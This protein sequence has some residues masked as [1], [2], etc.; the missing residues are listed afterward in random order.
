VGDE[1]KA[2]N[3]QGPYGEFTKTTKN[4]LYLQYRDTT[5]MEGDLQW[6]E[7]KKDRG[8]D[9]RGYICRYRKKVVRL[10]EGVWDGWVCQVGVIRGVIGRRTLKKNNFFLTVGN[11]AR[12]T[13]RLWGGNAPENKKEKRAPELW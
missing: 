4:L 13:S 2:G 8:G 5:L 10:M 7:K 11:V 1:V 9:K 12:K 3:R 6:K